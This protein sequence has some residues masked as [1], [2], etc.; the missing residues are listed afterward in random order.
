MATRPSNSQPGGACFQKTDGET[1]RRSRIVLPR[2]GSP[3]LENF[4]IPW[5]V[6]CWRSFPCAS[7]CLARNRTAPGSVRS[8]AGRSSSEWSRTVVSAATITADSPAGSGVA[9]VSVTTP[10]GTSPTAPADQFMYI[11]ATAPL[12]T[13]VERF[14]FHHQPTSLVLT[15][16]SALDPARVD[17]VNNYLIM[18]LGRGRHS[19]ALAG[20]LTPVRAA[21]Y[22]P[23]KLTVTL[24]MSKRISIH[25]SYRLTVN[26][27]ASSG[28]TSANGTALDRQAH[29]MQGADYVAVLS[30][31]LVAGPAP[32]AP[33]RLGRLWRNT[34]GTQKAP[35]PWG[36]AQNR[37]KA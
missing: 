29:G 15:V 37:S 30:G 3:G 11:A 19:K 33:L 28:L 4:R 14:G 1:V 17:D 16:S 9:N 10:S 6:P 20:H 24:Y 25:S 34:S 27:A 22:D 12:V 13:S 5:A 18:A 26:G 32:A 7:F 21:V 23:A 8:Q 35:C 31:K 2:P 36:A